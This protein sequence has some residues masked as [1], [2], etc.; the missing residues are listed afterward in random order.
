VPDLARLEKLVR[1]AK[2]ESQGTGPVICRRPEGSG[3]QDSLTKS[4]A[5]H[6]FSQAL[7]NGN[8]PAGRLTHGSPADAGGTP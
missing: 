5:L 6:F 4:A 2:G 7:A 1:E 3:Q 8:D